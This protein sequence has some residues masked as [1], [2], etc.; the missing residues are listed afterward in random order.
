[1]CIRDRSTEYASQGALDVAIDYMRRAIEVDRSIGYAHALGHDLIDFSNLH[2]LKGEVA[3]ARVAMLEALVWFGFN[4]DS[5]A[6]DWTHERL[7]ELDASGARSVLSMGVR[8]GVK[9]HLSLGEGKV[10]C[11][12]ESPLRQVRQRA[13]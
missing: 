8:G 11:E 2:L 5:D 9:S 1:M 6:L 7:A 12:F 4:E 3:E 13:V 10:Y